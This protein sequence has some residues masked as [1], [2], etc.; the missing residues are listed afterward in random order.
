MSEPRWLSATVVLAVHSDQIKAHGG[1]VGLRDQ[2]PFESALDRPRNRYHYEP[3]SDLSSLAASY[4]FGV[5]RNHPFVDGN[6]RVAFQCMYVFLGLTGLRI[7][8]PEE[9]VVTLMLAL[10]SGEVD[11]LG[12]SAWLRDHTVP[13]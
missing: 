2:G 8:S 1:S 6:K 10:A 4:G 9:E 5:A 7:D 3:E 12:L 13:R 11:E